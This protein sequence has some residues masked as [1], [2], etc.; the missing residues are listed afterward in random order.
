MSVDRVASL[1]QYL[2]H[3]PVG[4]TLPK[5]DGNGPYSGNLTLTEWSRTLP[6]IATNVPINITQGV[7]VQLY[8]AI[9]TG[10]GFTSG[11]YS[12]DGQSDASEYTPRLAQL[13]VQHQFLNGVWTTTQ[14]VDIV[15]FPQLVTWQE[16]LPGRLGLHIAPYIELDLF[17]LEIDPDAAWFH[18]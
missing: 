12:E 18:P 1:A 6:P 16:A 13:V 9:P 17:Y 4:L 10:W 2:A 7:Q 5:L 3:S 15:S 11:W 8:G 14:T